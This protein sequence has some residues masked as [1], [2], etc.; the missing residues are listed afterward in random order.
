MEP[1]EPAAT[2]LPLVL[3]V[4]DD[5]DIRQSFAHVLGDRGYDVVEAQHGQAALDYLATQPLPALIVLDLMMPVMSGEEFRRAQLADPRL[6]SIPVVVMSAAE[7]G[8]AIAA[9]LGAEF[10]P[11]PARMHQLLSAVK[12]HC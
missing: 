7:R 2:H 3:I 10:L 8:S 12:R 11:K 1:T 4:D 6:A 5:K 9:E